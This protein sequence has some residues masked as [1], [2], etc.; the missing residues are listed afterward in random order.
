MGADLEIRAVLDG[1]RSKVRRLRLAAG[2]IQLF[3]GRYTLHRVS[4]VLGN[5]ERY[6]A[7]PSWS[8]EPRMIGKAHRTKTIYGRLTAAHWAGDERRADALLD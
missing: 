5:V 2:D 6:I 3:M 4:E 7:I 1:D 8:V